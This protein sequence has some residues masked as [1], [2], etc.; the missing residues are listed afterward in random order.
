MMS[1]C[2]AHWAAANT[3]FLQSY[4]AEHFRRAA[5]IYEQLSKD[6]ESSAYE[7]NDLSI[8]S[9]ATDAQLQWKGEPEYVRHERPSREDLESFETAYNAACLNIAKGAFA[10][11]EVLLNRAKNICQTSEDLSPEDRAAELLP[12]AVQHLYVLIR[13]GKTEEADALIKDLSVEE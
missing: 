10:Q 13:Q 4:R 7:A 3:F 8:N 1:N 9:W 11:G 6:R 2:A 5:D 12:I